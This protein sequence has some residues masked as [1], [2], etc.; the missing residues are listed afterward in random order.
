MIS[1]LFNFLLNYQ[2]L[3]LRNKY[4]KIP[5]DNY[6][7]Q[8]YNKYCTTIFMITIEIV[9]NT[10]KNIFFFFNITANNNYFNIFTYIIHTVNKLLKN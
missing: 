4:F 1:A 3:N 9:L 2:L 8:W 5:D 10:Y 7:S 6:R